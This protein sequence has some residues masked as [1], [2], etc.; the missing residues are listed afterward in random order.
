MLA[1]FHGWVQKGFIDLP[2]PIN[3]LSSIDIVIV[4]HNHYDHLDD[5]TVRDLADKN[6]IHVVV[7]LGLKP[8][9]IERGYNKFTELDWGQSVSVEGIKVTAEPSVNDS[10]RSTSDHNKTLW[11]SWIISSFQQRIFFISDTVYSKIILN[12]VGDKYGSF[13]FAILPTGAFEPRELLW[14]SHTTPEEAISIG[15][16]VRTKTLIASHW[17]IISSSS[18]R[19]MF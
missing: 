12:L 8:F 18:D 19:P 11:S 10:T 6:N 14:T 7:P 2:I 15:I 9:F 1:L 17:C 4:S 3:R 13:D 5:K 16:D